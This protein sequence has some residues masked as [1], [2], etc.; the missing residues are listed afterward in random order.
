MAKSS[1][2]RRWV[3]LSLKIAVTVGLL[4]YVVWQIEWQ[5]SL[6]LDDGSRVRGWAKRVDGQLILTANG[7]TYAIPLEAPNAVSPFAP[8]F[9]RLIWEVNKALLFLVCLAMPVPGLAQAVRWQ[10]LLRT[11]K[12]DP[13]FL[14]A[15]KLTWIG[16]F[17]NNV[18]PG[19]TGGDV[20][21]GWCIYRRAP[22]QRMDAIMTVLMDRV[23]GLV[24]LLLIG[25]LAIVSQ[26]N[27]QAMSAPRKAVFGT[28]AVILIGG[29]I[30]FSGRLRRLLRVD[31]WLPRLPFGAGI[32]R[33]DN[34]L[35][36]YRSHTG[37][38]AACVGLS[39]LIHFWFVGI[40]ATLGRALDINVPLAYYF[41][42]V[43]IIFTAGAVLPSIA[44]LGVLEGGFAYFFGLPF[45]GARP[46]AAVA[47]CLL[48]RAL[49]ILNSLPGW[50]WFNREVA[51]S[52]NGAASL[53]NA[54][55][56]DGE[57]AT[58]AT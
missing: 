9:F 33:I 16:F 5:D 25:G 2:W 37:V 56:A 55:G 39:L 51:A 10:W 52:R 26:A 24:S 53:E 28:L 40:V 27:N 49:N 32:Q 45:V 20:A 3:G 50:I 57:A 47:V 43:P 38:L 54:L 4:A 6:R 34:S 7:Q 29:A 12:L 13:G 18:L 17:A 22:G 21:K 23:L 14:E 1:G 44:G 41:M 31:V 58:P 48:Y 46:S 11:H 19:S 36:H 35:F 30:F 42:F 8:G 15:A